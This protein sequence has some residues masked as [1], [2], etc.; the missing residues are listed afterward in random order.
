MKAITPD[1]SLILSEEFGIW[2]H[3]PL[4]INKHG[5]KPLREIRILL[6]GIK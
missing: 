6:M 2:S 3:K 1:I 5:I 4:E